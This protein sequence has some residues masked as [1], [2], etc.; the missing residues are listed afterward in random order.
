M[1]ITF[2]IGG[3][4][5]GGAERVISILANHYA[6]KGWNVDIVLL[7]YPNVQYEL[8]QNI[9]I[10]DMAAGE[11]SYI[12]KVP[13][14]IKKIRKY[15]IKE[16]PDRIVSFVGRINMLVLTASIG[17]KKSIIVSER[18]D[19]KNDG[20]GKIIQK[21]CNIIYRRAKAIVFQTKYEKSCFSK[22]LKQAYIIPNPVTVNINP[23]L[24]AKDEI[25]TAGRLQPQKNQKVLI[26]AFNVIH[27]MYPG[28]KLKIY[29][30]GILKEDLL[31]Q[32]KEYKLENEVELCGNVN[33]LHKRIVGSRL[34][35]LTSEYEGLSNALIE[36]MMLGIPCISTDY[37]G[38]NEIIK[39]N[40]NGVIVKRNDVKD[41]CRGIK[42]V[43]E[44]KDFSERIS[45]NA[46][47]D[48]KKYSEK[49]I[50]KE[51]EKVIE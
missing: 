37:P 28:L 43:L 5:R 24:C 3:M 27:K 25:V 30:D 22:K 10:I 46:L 48:S 2:F 19:P 11:G 45:K 36:A 7:L 21:Y 42:K 34:F 20:R 40:Y 33:D 29:G 32:V 4:K 16:K 26:E 9:N 49:V 51:W 12:K 17:L 1:K 6:K 23:I 14:W 44:N 41:I 15:I 13:K 38:V 31:T 8:N 47:E 35:I 18:N 39:N 50:I